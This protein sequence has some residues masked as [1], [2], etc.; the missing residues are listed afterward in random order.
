[1]ASKHPV[2]GHVKREKGYL[3]FVDKHGAVRKVKARRTGAK[4]GHKTC[5]APRRSKGRR[6]KR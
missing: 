3:Y 4:R 6:S 1:M 5:Y 2:V